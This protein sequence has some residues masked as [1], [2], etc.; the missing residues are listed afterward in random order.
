M[1]DKCFMKIILLCI[2]SIAAATLNFHKSEIPY[3]HQAF[4][5]CKLSSGDLFYDTVYIV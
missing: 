3:S 2:Y 5:E 1:S 4:Y